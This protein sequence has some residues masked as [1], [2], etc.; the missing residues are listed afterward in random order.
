LDPISFPQ[1]GLAIASPSAADRFNQKIAEEDGIGVSLIPVMQL[2]KE[3]QMKREVGLWIDRHKTVIVT[4]LN[5]KEETREILS[6][7]EKHVRFSG[8]LHMKDANG[9]VMSTAEDVGDRRFENHLNGY[10]DGVVSM[11]RNADSI[12]IFGPGEAKAEL[13]KRLNDQD[14]GGRIVSVETV[15]KMTNRQIVAKVRH[16]YKH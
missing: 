13:Q 2:T 14:L 7:V 16:H 8:A 4:M 12:W 9:S 6:N 3:T 11:L 10:F 15:D 1:P 5:E